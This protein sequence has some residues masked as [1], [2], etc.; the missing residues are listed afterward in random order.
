VRDL[1]LD[2]R[3]GCRLFG[4]PF[5]PRSVPTPVLPIPPDVITGFGNLT[6]VLP[7]RNPEGEE[8][9]GAGQNNDDHRAGPTLSVRLR[10]I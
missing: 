4:I 7:F 5:K 3:E 9:E 10:P 1:V 2:G 6:L 8:T